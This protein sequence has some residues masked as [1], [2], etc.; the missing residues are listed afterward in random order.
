MLHL[1]ICSDCRDEVQLLLVSRAIDVESHR[2]RGAY[3]PRPLS[4]IESKDEL[5]AYARS[6]VQGTHSRDI[7]S[8]G[9]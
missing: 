8:K 5:G 6:R 4:G 1:T 9:W 7:F 3:A 2:S